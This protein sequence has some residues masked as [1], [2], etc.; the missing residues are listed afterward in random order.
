MVQVTGRLLCIILLAPPPLGLDVQAKNKVLTYSHGWACL[1]QGLPYHYNYCWLLC[2]FS[3]VWG[4]SDAFL[5]R[6]CSLPCLCRTGLYWGATILLTDTV[7]HA[8]VVAWVARPHEKV[9]CLHYLQP[10]FPCNLQ[11]GENEVCCLH[12]QWPLQS[13]WVPYPQSRLHKRKHVE[14]H[15]TLRT[16]ESP[17]R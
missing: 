17:Y 4:N 1:V 2:S 7:T 5:F 11:D 16:A 10:N 14:W 12:G 8:Q 3:R 15:K 9:P 13:A 6:K